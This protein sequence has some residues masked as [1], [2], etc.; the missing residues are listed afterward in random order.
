MLWVL[1]IRRSVLPL[2]TCSFSMFFYN[3]RAPPTHDPFTGILGRQPRGR[4]AARL[5]SPFPFRVFSP[6]P[7]LSSFPIPL[8]HTPVGCTFPQCC[9]K[10][11]KTS[12]AHEIVDTV[13]PV[14]FPQERGVEKRAREKTG[15]RG[16]NKQFTALSPLSMRLSLA[17]R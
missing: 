17:S 12:L 13:Q 7:P 10:R 4:G 11:C 9:T 16:E 5:Q 1:G 2:V 8:W 6:S 15:E 3:L 14:R